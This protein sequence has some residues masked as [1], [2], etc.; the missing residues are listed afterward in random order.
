M[1]CSACAPPGR[2]LGA[3]Q[4]VMLMATTTAMRAAQSG[5]AG[6]L[7]RDQCAAVASTHTTAPGDTAAALMAAAYPGVPWEPQW[8]LVALCNAAARRVNP[9]FPR[10][11]AA[12]PPGLRL[13][14][15]VFQ[16][17]LQ[18][19]APGSDADAPPVGVA[20]AAGGPPPS[21]LC[22][23]GPGVAVEGAPHSW[24]QAAAAASPGAPAALAAHALAACNPRAA[25]TP[26]RLLAPGQLL[27]GVCAGSAAASANASSAAVAVAAAD[28]RSAARLR[29]SRRRSRPAGREP[30]GLTGAAS[31]AAARSGGGG[32]GGGGGSRARSGSSGGGGEPAPPARGGAGRSGAAAAGRSSAQRP[33]AG[34]PSGGAAAPGGRPRGA[35]RRG[36]SQQRRQQ[37]AG[38]GGGPAAPSAPEPQTACTVTVVDGGQ[39]PVRTLAVPEACG[40]AWYAD[41]CSVPGTL[42]RGLQFQELLTPCC[43]A[44]DVCYACAWKLGLSGRRALRRAPTRRGA[45]RPAPGARPPPDRARRCAPP[46]PPRVPRRQGRRE[47]DRRMLA[48]MKA[49]CGEAHAPRGWWDWSAKWTSFCTAHAAVGPG[50]RSEGCGGWGGAPMDQP[51][52][53]EGGTPVPPASELQSVIAWLTAHGFQE[54]AA[55]VCASVGGPDALVGQDAA[56]GSDDDAAPYSESEPFDVQEPMRSRSAEAVLE[57]RG[58]SEED[59]A[60]SERPCSPWAPGEPGSLTT[61]LSGSS[62]LYEDPDVDEYEGMEDLGYVRRSVPNQQD[63]ILHQLDLLDSDGEYG[64]PPPPGAGAGAPFG[65]GGGGGGGLGPPSRSASSSA[66]LSSPGASGALQRGASGSGGLEAPTGDAAWDSGPAGIVFAEPVTTPTRDSRRSSLSEPKPGGL[67]R[68]ESLSN[69]FIDELDSLDGGN[70]EASRRG[71]EAGS[72]DRGGSR[73]GLGGG[74]GGGGSGGAPC[75]GLDA[76]DVIDLSPP[77]PPPDCPADAGIDLSNIFELGLRGGSRTSSVDVLGGS[78]RCW[79]ETDSELG[80]GGGGGGGGDGRPR[81]QQSGA[82]SRSAPGGARP[83][84]PSKLAPPQQPSAAARPGQDEEAQQAEQQQAPAAQQQ[85][86]PAAQQACEQP[87]AAEPPPQEQQEQQEQLQQQQDREQGQQQRQQQQQQ[88]Q[89]GAGLPPVAAPAGGSGSSGGG[90]CGGG[91]GGLGGFSFPTTPPSAVDAAVHEERAER[92]F[93][94]WASNHSRSGLEGGASD[95][96]GDAVTSKPPLVVSRGGSGEGAAGAADARE[97]PWEFPTTPAAVPPAAPAQQAAA[98]AAPGTGGSSRSG[99]AAGGGAAGAAGDDGG[100][101]G[102]VVLAAPVSPATPFS[103]AAA[104]GL[105]DA[106]TGGSSRAGSRPPSSSG[107]GGSRAPGCSSGGSSRLKAGSQGGTPPRP[108]GLAG[109][110]AASDAA[111]PAGAGARGGSA[112]GAGSAP[113]G[114]PDGA[115]PDALPPRF[116][117]EPGG[118]AGPG[119]DAELASTGT[120]GYAGSGELPAPRYVVDGE[121]NLLYEYDAAYVEQWYETFDLRVIHRRRRTGFEDSKEFPIRKNDLIAGRYQVMD[122]LGSAAFSQAVQALDTA[123]GA[124]VCLKIIKNNK[125]YFD[126]SLDEIKLL[127]YV[128]GSDPDDEQHIVRLYDFFYYKEHLFLVCELLRANLYEF[129]KYQRENGDE[130]YFTPPRIQRIAA[131]VLRALAFLHSLG[132]VHSDLKPENILI[133]SYS[134]CEVKVIDLGSSCFITDHLSSYVQSRSYRAPEVILGL[135][136]GQ[137]VDLWSLGCILA[138]LATGYVLFQ[139]DSLATLLV[140]LEGILGPLPGWMVSTGRY[141]HRFYTRGR[142]IYERNKAT[143]RYEVLVPKRTSLRHR[144]PGGDE[145]FLDFLAY[146]LTPDPAARPSAADALAHPWLSHPYPPLEQLCTDGGRAERG[147]GTCFPAAPGPSGPP[148]ERAMRDVNMLLFVCFA[149]AAGAGAPAAAASRKLLGGADAAATSCERGYFLSAGACLPCP[150]GTF[151]AGGARTACT[152]CAAPYSTPGEASP[153]GNCTVCKPG[154]G[155]LLS[156]EQFGQRRLISPLG[157]CGGCLSSTYSGGGAGAECIGCPTGLVTLR[158]RST[159]VGDCIP[160]PPKRAPVP[161]CTSPLA[162]NPKP[163]SGGSYWSASKGE[164]VACPPGSFAPGGPQTITGCVPCATGYATAGTASSGDSCSVC[165]AGYGR[166]SNGPAVACAVCGRGTYSAGGPPRPCTRCPANTTTAGTGSTGLLDCLPVAPVVDAAAQKAALLAGVDELY[167]RVWATDPPPDAQYQTRGKWDVSADDVCRPPWERIACDARGAITRIDLIVQDVAGRLPRAWDALAPSLAKIVITNWVD[168][169]KPNAILADPSWPDSWASFPVLTEITLARIT[170]AGGPPRGAQL[171]R[172]LTMLG[173]GG[174]LSGTLPDD[175]PARLPRLRALSLDG[176][177]LLGGPLPESWAD[178]SSLEELNLADCALTGALPAAWGAGALARRLRVALLGGNRLS[179]PLPESWSG[180]TSLRLLQLVDNPLLGG[181]LPRTWWGNMLSLRSLNLGSA[182]LTGGLPDELAAWAA[183]YPADGSRGGITELD[184]HGNALAGSLPAAWRGFGCKGTLDLSGNALTGELPAEWVSFSAVNL[185]SNKLTGPLPSLTGWAS[186]GSLSA[187]DNRLSGKLPSGLGAWKGYT[188][189]VA[190]NNLTGPLPAAWAGMPNLGALDLSGNPLCT[191]LPA[192]WGGLRVYDLRINDARLTGTVPLSWARNGV[193]RLAIG[194]NPSL[195]GCLPYR[196]RDMGMLAARK[197]DGGTPGACGY[198]PEIRTQNINPLPPNFPPLAGT[199]ITGWPPT[200]AGYNLC[201]WDCAQ[202]VR[203]TT[204]PET[205]GVLQVDVQYKPIPGVNSTMMVWMFKNMAGT[206]VR[207]SPASA[208]APARA[209]WRRAHAAAA[210][211]AAAAQ[212]SPVDGKTYPMYLMFHPRDHMYHLATNPADRPNTVGVGTNFTWCE[213]SLTGCS[214]DARAPRYPWSCPA[215]A[216]GFTRATPLADYNDKLQTRAVMT[217]RRFNAG[218]IEFSRWES[219]AL[220]RT[221]R[222]VGT[223]RHAWSDSPDGLRLHTSMFVGLMEPGSTTSFDT[224]L[225]SRIAANT[226]KEKMLEGVENLPSG[227]AT[228][229]GWM[230]ALHFLEE[231]GSTKNWLPQVWAASHVSRSLEQVACATRAWLALACCAA[232]ALRAAAEPV[233]TFDDPQLAATLQAAAAPAATGVLKPEDLPASRPPPSSTGYKL[234]SWNCAQRVRVMTAPDIPGVLQLDVQYNPIPGVNSTMMDW[235]FKNLAGDAVYAGDGK[236]YPM[237]LIFHPRDHMFHLAANP[238]NRPDSVGVGTNFTWCEMIMTGCK[239]NPTR[240]TNS[241]SCPATARGFVRSTPPADYNTKFQTLEVMRVRSFKAGGIEFNRWESNPFFGDRIVATTRHTWSDTPDG[242]RLRSQFFLGLMKTA[243]PSRFETGSLATTVNNVIRDRVLKGATN[244]PSG[245]AVA[246]GWMNALHFIEEYGSTKNWLP[247]GRGASRICKL[248]SRRRSMQPALLLAAA[249]R[250][251]LR[252]LLLPSMGVAGTRAFS[253]PGVRVEKDTMGALEVPADKYWG[254]Q[255]QRSLQNFKIGG[256]RERMPEPIIR[257]FGVLKGAAAKVNMASGGLDPKIGSAIVS[258]AGEVA[259]G[260]LDDHFPLVIWQTGSGTQSNMN[261]NEVIANRAIEL[262]GGELGSKLVHPNDHV[263]KGQSSNDTFPSVMHIAAATEAHAV[264]LPQL[265]ELHAALAGKAAEFSSIIKIGRTHTMDATPLTLGQ[266]FGGYAQQVAYGIA[267]VRAALPALYR[268]AQG[269]TAVGTGL[270]TKPGFD[271]AVAAQVAADTGLPFVTAPNKFEALAAHD[272]LVEVS[273]AL[274]VLA[275][276]L[277]KVANDVRLLGSGPRCGLGELLLPENEPGSSIMPGKVNPTQCEALTMVAAQVMGNNAGLSIAGSNGHFELNVFKPMMGASLLQST[278]LLGDAAGSFAANC[279]VGIQANRGR[280]DQLLHESLML[281]TALNPKIGYDNAA[282]AAKKA[283]KEGTTLKQA[284]MAL[285]LLSSEEF[286]AWSCRARLVLVRGGEEAGPGRPEQWPGPLGASVFE[287]GKID[288]SFIVLDDRRQGGPVGAAPPGPGSTARELEE[289]FVVLPGA[290]SVL[291]PGGG[292]GSGGGSLQQQASGGA[293]AP[294][295]GGSS[296]AAAVAAAAAAAAGRGAARPQ[297]PG[298]GGLA[299]KLDALAALCEL[300]STATGVDHPLC[301]DCAAQL[302]DEVGAQVA[303]LEA[304]VSAYGAALS[305]LSADAPAELGAAEFDAEMAQLAAATAAARADAAAAD[306]EAASVRGAL[307][308]ARR[309]SAE[310]SALEERYWHDLNAY[311]LALAGHLSDRDSLLRRIDRSGQQLLLLQSTSVLNDAFR[312]W[313][314]GPFGTISG[315]RLGRT[316]EVAVEWDEINAAWGQAVLLLHTMAQQCKLN[317]S[318]YRLLPM[319]S[320]PR[321][322]DKRGTYDLYGPVHKLWGS[323]YDKAMAAYLAC[324]K[325]FGDFARARDVAEGAASVFEFPFAIEGDKVGNYTI[326][327]SMLNKDAKWTKALKLM[328][329]DLKVALQWMIGYVVDRQLAEICA[330]IAAPHC[331]CRA[332]SGQRRRPRDAAA[333]AGMLDFLL[334]AAVLVAPQGNLALLAGIG[335]VKGA[336]ALRRRLARGGEPAAP[337]VEEEG[338][339]DAAMLRAA[340]PTPGAKVPPVTLEWEGLSCHWAP[341]KK[342]KQQLTSDGAP[343][344]GGAKQILFG[345]SGAARPG[346]LLALMGPSGSGKTTLLNAMANHVPAGTGMRLTGGLYVNGV[347]SS[348]SNHRQAYV[349]QSDNFYSMLTVDETLGMAGALQLR[350]SLPEDARGAVVDGLISVLGLAKSRGT[351]VGDEKVRG[352]S[353]GEKKRL[354]IGCELISSPSLIFLDEPTTGLDSFQAEKVVATLKDLASSGHTVVCSIH[355]PRSSI[356]ALFDDLLLLSEGRTV[357]AGPAA[358]ALDYFE[359]LGHACPAHYNPAEFVAD[360]ISIDFTTPEAEAGSRA[361][362]DALAAAWAQAEAAAATAAAGAAGAHHIAR[363]ASGEA[364][365]GAVSPR[366]KAGW[367]RQFALLLRRSWRQITRD[368]AAAIARLSSNLSSAV[369]FGAIFWRMGRKQSSIQDRMGLL[370]A[371]GRRELHA[372]AP[373]RPPGGAALCAGARPQP[374]PFPCSRRR[375]RV[376]VAAINTAMSALVKTITVFPRERSIVAR[377]RSRRAYDVL[378]YLSAKLLAE[379]PVSCVFPLVFG[380]VVY[381]VTGLDLRPAKFAKFL[382]VLT[383]ESFTSAALGLAVGAAAPSTDAAVAIGPAVMLVWIIFGG[384]YANPENIPRALRWLPQASLIKHAFEALCINEFGGLEF[385]LDDN[386]RGMKTGEDVLSW[387]SFGHTSIGRTLGAEARILAF[388]YWLTY[389]I[390]KAGKPRF[391]AVEPGPAVVVE[392]L[393]AEAGGAAAPKAAAALPAPGAPPRALAPSGPAAAML[394]TS[395]PGWRGLRRGLGAPAARGGGACGSSAPLLAVAPARRR[396]A[397]SGAGAESRP[398]VVD[399]TVA[400]APDAPARRGVLLAAALAAAWAAA[401]GGAH[402]APD[403]PAAGASP[404][405]LG[406]LGGTA[407]GDQPAAARQQDEAPQ[408]QEQQVEAEDEDSS[409]SSDDDDAE[410]GAADDDSSSSSSSSSSGSD[411]EEQEAKNNGGNAGSGGAGGAAQRRG[412]GD[413]GPS[414]SSEASSPSAGG[415]AGSSAASSPASGGPSAKAVPANLS[416]SAYVAILQ[417]ARRAAWPAI[418][419]RIASGEWIALSQALNQPPFDDVRQACF[420][421]PWA[422]LQSDDGAAAVAARRNYVDFIN[423]VHSLAGTALRA[424]DGEPGAAL[425]RPSRAARATRVAVRAQ[426]QQA[427]RAAAAAALCKR[428]LLVAGVAAVTVASAGRAAADPANPE[429]T[430]KVFFDVSVGGAPAGRIVMGLY[431]NETP[432]TAANFAALATGEKGFGYKGCTFH[433]IIKDFVIQGGDFERGNGTGGYSIYGRKFED[434]NFAVPHA[435]GVLSM[436]NAGR[437]T[438]GSQFFITTADTPWLNG[439]HVVFGRVLEGLDVVDRLQNVPADRG[440]RPAQRVRSVAGRQLWGGI[441]L[442]VHPGEV[443]FLRGPSGVGK[444]L[445]LRALACLDPLEAGELL[446]EGR[447]PSEMGTP[448]WRAQVM[449]VH[450]SRINFKGTPLEFFEQV[451]NFAA[452]R[453]RP[454]GDL[455]ALVEELGLLPG[456][457]HQQWTE[458]SGGQAQRVGLAIALALKPAVLLLDE[459][460]SACDHVSVLKVEAVLQRC[461]S[462]IVWVTHDVLQPSRVGGRVLELPSGA[463]G[464]IAP[465]DDAAL[466]AMSRSASATSSLVGASP[467]SSRGDLLMLQRD[468]EATASFS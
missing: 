17:L 111:A 333:S 222:A 282:A 362:V 99:S 53:A 349:E 286:D 215:S 204:A 130:P 125:D 340:T 319:G 207:E 461:P 465:M 345:L 185:D 224:T 424:A 170:L 373:A 83:K 449:Y 157:T 239:Y 338:G 268:L 63:F 124:L 18:L 237:Y 218:G 386:G 412:G 150:V 369:I 202:R 301:L 374:L 467:S 89:A 350:Q 68:V 35:G 79:S 457:L 139:N 234:C 400:D 342:K 298:G 285:G 208:P 129:Q 435:P 339:G 147:S 366:P 328:L 452:Q 97:S 272:S 24:L 382:G 65:G 310:V 295:P 104:V 244:L 84:P 442:D 415:G 133:K 458:L 346:R 5:G 49:L 66:S 153:P 105:R 392:E 42:E 413:G 132:L 259:A 341:K 391:Q 411:E 225:L 351:R 455:A 158:G 217:V 118:A 114:A 318:A 243:V 410:Q 70:E 329:A 179:G 13:A 269:G 311:Q 316:P 54:A 283:H 381:P 437:N 10:G 96:E 223:A 431:G 75:L 109:S 258:A 389:S 425:Q 74:R 188:L 334:G 375:G 344:S 126:Q 255:T 242:L 174:N 427:E 251:A 304:E 115:G 29:P 87:L 261:A 443:W 358:A 80:G 315:F 240:K 368:K 136:Y 336:G 247:Q 210:A 422:L 444:T 181:P 226:I 143:G 327:L 403:A 343:A 194:G 112:S 101:G 433:R 321:V 325:E 85:L 30:P 138:E 7:W 95:D 423:H 37:A 393:P 246:Y 14:L 407:S 232:L 320:C 370:Q 169:A 144:V 394:V 186:M 103:P 200:A 60:G 193:M 151:S 377:E 441:S 160:P 176:N 187:S 46:P 406:Q 214:Y 257:A 93:S 371:R 231:Y 78:M 466:M 416:V 71:S 361:C 405:W 38:P 260:K 123:T 408:Q 252:G 154:Y 309:A 145:G 253:S 148:P 117:G 460:T 352:L 52:Q 447:S 34:A 108:P 290:A 323:S 171:P 119:G 76:V 274:N 165:A 28:A 390:L 45:A 434:E 81:S 262:L 182:N 451:Q 127:R 453:G 135:G 306:A 216:R 220:L 86:A 348:D 110:A 72:L 59:Y 190:R 291:R 417:A 122:F 172:S 337:T 279:V 300:A 36:Q 116:A 296:T 284:A 212:V 439:K 380:A 15:P 2:P 189:V 266:E 428:E 140:R 131:Q 463:V 364:A 396:A 203:V 161:Q 308:A 456:V 250:G 254:A 162:A 376:Q 19:Q 248:S 134:R 409:S 163:C 6:E 445:L 48:N 313:H 420:Y 94:T 436:A 64:A 61:R 292:A 256:P 289:S 55:V 201:S 399:D 294:P 192:E 385:D 468:A 356:F 432:R 183:H 23:C 21:A 322:A 273:G 137:K 388:Y 438:N 454:R 426:Q 73:G 404:S 287:G 324:L 276:S 166:P 88:Q 462:S 355:Q 384:Y 387:L 317:F 227:N 198:L 450:Q 47:C 107:A 141:G 58:A 297:H 354:A 305:R 430:A 91:G 228:A 401:A 82:G 312:I 330:A 113:R 459:P 233:A 22:G 326:R 180:M 1:R 177:P 335:A 168:S 219:H 197:C 195:G 446:L 12:L 102:C 92:V 8:A 398:G 213:M 360:L 238:A 128:N 263:N 121:G 205:R 421:I 56:R 62:R 271:V 353:G 16:P 159:S 332:Q 302:R 307:A 167:G 25:L 365:L 33:P 429:V 184:L 359:A 230:N 196:G 67:S 209:P 367:R 26:G 27:V 156:I 31:A 363:T 9:G 90:A 331:H 395:T 293:G 51:S 44:H 100:A 281:V 278:R 418:A 173:L 20:A 265:E 40:G 241:W 57:S 69:S 43:N 178:W 199:A 347:P 448:C 39:G 379:L 397:R 211:A 402:A 106:S 267:R 175:Y 372:R 357:Y 303:E 464:T 206:A 245:D 299:A 229:Y 146:L 32:G 11:D 77:S 419:Q 4:F 235:M 280:I 152:A 383:L 264:L 236:T 3:L 414:T 378:P 149:I 270:N 142:Q 50:A 314:D 249:R 155:R 191:P 98:A 41:G 120:G 440:G 288:E 221:P 164:C 275:V 277:M